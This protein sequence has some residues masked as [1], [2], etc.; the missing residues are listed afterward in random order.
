[1]QHEIAF[2]NFLYAS[3]SS[4]PQHTYMV[5][6]DY[7]CELFICL[8]NRAIW[9]P[10]LYVE[11]SDRPDSSRVE[12]SGWQGSTAELTSSCSFKWRFNES[13]SS[14]ERK[15]LLCVLIHSP[16]PPSL[17][18][19]SRVSAW[20]HSRHSQTRLMGGINGLRLLKSFFMSHK[21]HTLTFLIVSSLTIFISG[22][23]LPFSSFAS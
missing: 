7:V 8:D 23:V 22:D 4:A 10:S 18:L 15:V 2:K 11:H 17:F 12:F 6:R 14:S 16:S 20:R 3:S 9:S 5:W 21:F 19:L 13:S 1:M